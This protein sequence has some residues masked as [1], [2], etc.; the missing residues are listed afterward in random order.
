MVASAWLRASTSSLRRLSS[1]AWASASL[2]MRS[3]SASVSPP[4][5][6][7]RMVCSLPLALSFADTFTIPFRVDIERYLDLRQAARGR[8]NA[9]EVE[10]SQ[11]FVVGRH[12]A[13]ALE[14]ADG[15]RRLIV[16]RCRE[17]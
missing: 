6:W 13:F 1:S 17:G 10:L 3:M 12:F 5:A 15:N 16:F 8:W 11:Q 14:D 9:D 4:D 7:M 2:T